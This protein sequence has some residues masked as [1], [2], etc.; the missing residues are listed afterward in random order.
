MRATATGAVLAVVPPMRGYTVAAVTAAASDRRFI[1]DEEPLTA[2]GQAAKARG[3]LVDPQP[4][5][6][7]PDPGHRADAVHR[8]RDGGAERAGHVAPR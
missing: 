1:L 8:T 7:G 6:R 5:R 3:R 2:A 4:D